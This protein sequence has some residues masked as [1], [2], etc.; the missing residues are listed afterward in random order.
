MADA[1]G[2]IDARRNPKA[3]QRRVIHRIFAHAEVQHVAQPRSPGFFNH[4]Q[5][6]FDEHPIFAGH[7][8]AIR[9]RPD[10]DEIEAPFQEFFG[11]LRGKQARTERLRQ[12]KR[13]AHAGQ[14]REWI[15]AI[16]P[17]RVQ[18]RIRGRQRAGN[19]MMIADNHVNSGIAGAANRVKAADAVIHRDDEIDLVARGFLHEMRLKAVAVMNPVRQA[20]NHLLH[21]DFPKCFIQH[22]RAGDAVGVIIA[23]NHDAL[24]FLLRLL[25]PVN[26]A[27]HIRQ[28]KRI[29]QIGV[30]IRA[31][32]SVAVINPAV[33]QQNIKHRIVFVLLM[34]KMPAFFI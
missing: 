15:R 1:P 2:G 17:P 34:K 3:D 27:F 33:S 21:A 13:H 23:D 18:N 26:H 30:E 31:Q 25:Q 32:K 4:N 12:F 7:G 24:L 19:R 6:V 28:Q 22:R 5:A 16:L 11:L 10:G 14:I 9:H 29:V 20:A 8:R